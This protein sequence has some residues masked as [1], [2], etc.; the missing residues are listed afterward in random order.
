M[1]YT[2]GVQVTVV[3]EIEVDAHSSVDAEAMATVLENVVGADDIIDVLP[4]VR[5]N[6]SHELDIANDDVSVYGFWTTHAY[7]HEQSLID[8]NE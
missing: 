8:N 7:V 3:L 4:W 2:I 1:K 5:P 6:V